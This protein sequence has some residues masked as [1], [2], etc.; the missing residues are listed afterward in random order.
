MVFWGDGSVLGKIA[1][2]FNHIAPHEPVIRKAQA[3]GAAAVL[4]CRYSNTEIYPGSS[5]FT[6][7]ASNRKE[8]VIPVF[9]TMV[10]KR[11]DAFLSLPINTG[12]TMM[13]Q[14]NRYVIPARNSFQLFA[15]LFQTFLEFAIIVVGLYRLREFFYFSEGQFT[16]L[17]IG[18]VCILFEIVGAFLRVA[19]TSVDPFYTYRLMS[20]KASMVLVTISFPFTLSAGILLTFFCTFQTVLPT[21][22]LPKEPCLG[23]ALWSFRC[24]SLPHSPSLDWSFLVS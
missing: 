5:M 6:V 14:P 16:F 4:I 17:S 10:R 13:I 2:F 18:P 15:N 24:L 8:L 23:R 21:L 7:D 22:V 19:Y 20:D 9:E 1:V 12:I 11:T 3:A